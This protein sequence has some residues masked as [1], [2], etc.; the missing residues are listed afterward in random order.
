MNDPQSQ[1]PDQAR[2]GLVAAFLVAICTFAVFLPVL[3]N[4]FVNWDDPIYVG[5]QPGSLWTA[6]WQVHPSGNWHPLATLSHRLDL[7]V[8]GHH[9]R[10]HHLTSIVLHALNAGLMV[11][12]AEA[13][14]RARRQAAPTRGALIALSL[15]AL[16]WSVHPLRVESVAW[17]SERKDL[18]CGFFYL[19]GLRAY[20]RDAGTT[21][22]PWYAR[23]SYWRTVACFVAALL[24]KPMAVSFPLVLLLLDWFPLARTE[25]QGLRKLIAEK[26]PLF[27]LSL[28]AGL[29]AVHAQ[30]AAGAFRALDDVPGTTRVLVALQAIGGYVGKLLW[31]SPLLPYYSY[32]DEPSLLSVLVASSII[33]LAAVLAFRRRRPAIVATIVAYLVLLSPV[34]GIV[35]VGP[36]AMADRYTY[37]A[38][39][40]LVVLAAAAAT[41]RRGGRVLAVPVVLVIGLLGWLTSAQI[42][43]WQDSE[44]LWTHQLAH[45]PDNMEARNSRA[46]FYY[47]HARYR[48][49][50]ADYDAAL[51]APARMS[52]RHA[53]KRRAACLNDRAITHVQ[54]GNLESAIRDAS[55]AIA[56]MPAQASYYLNRGEMYERLNLPELARVDRQRARTLLAPGGPEAR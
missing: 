13:L 1:P 34:L 8:W 54:L 53:S 7:L 3:R 12:L 32:P 19:L 2:A 18:L 49:A 17:V 24:S 40:P 36:Q 27:G 9:P 22:R 33:A 29:V 30:G 20:L 26:L 37:L 28:A 4:G 50:L 38:T 21:T 56:L 23:G 35:Q 48:E 43:V 41:A 45:E 46:S 16:A 25:R 5:T 6:L 15:A 31:P 51:A 55:E 39:I 14:L 42:R 11:L 52:A 47:E 44:A 10:G